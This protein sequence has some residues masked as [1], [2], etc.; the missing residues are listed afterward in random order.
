MLCI[1]P[2]PREKALFK[3]SGPLRDLSAKINISSRDSISRA[4][5]KKRTAE[6]SDAI[7]DSPEITFWKKDRLEEEIVDI[8]C[9]SSLAR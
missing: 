4:P 7:V 9:P 2:Q 1:F 3:D 5:L 8:T 6:S